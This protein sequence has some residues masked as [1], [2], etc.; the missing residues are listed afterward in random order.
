MQVS[1][2]R[3]FLARMLVLAATLVVIA[4]PAAPQALACGGDGEAEPLRINGELPGG[5]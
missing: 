5:G 4:G 2:T 1:A 3:S